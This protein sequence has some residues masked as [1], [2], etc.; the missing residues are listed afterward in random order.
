VNKNAAPF[1]IMHGDK[2]D[3]VPIAQS[4]ELDAALKKAGVEVTFQTI[5]GAGHGFGIKTAEL[6]KPIT[7]F[8]DKHL[9]AK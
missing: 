8:F 6:A 2:D 1:L 7:E 4:E 5:T 3:F 9:K